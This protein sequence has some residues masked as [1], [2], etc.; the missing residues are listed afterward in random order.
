MPGISKVLEVLEKSAPYLAFLEKVDLFFVDPLPYA[1]EGEMMLG[2]V[3]V[4]YSNNALG[5]FNF[6]LTLTAAALLGVIGEKSLVFLY[7]MN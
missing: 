3:V 6:V 4:F 1:L 7:F 2:R 5:F